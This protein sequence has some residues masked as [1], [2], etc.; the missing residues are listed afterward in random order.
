MLKDKVSSAEIAH[1]LISYAGP[2][3]DPRVGWCSASP[4]HKDLFKC[5]RCGAENL[6][7]SKIDHSNDCSAKE[8]LDILERVRAF[9]LCQK[10]K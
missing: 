5:E 6:D 10:T 2:L 9:G 7:L 4:S 3:S 1:A 8:I